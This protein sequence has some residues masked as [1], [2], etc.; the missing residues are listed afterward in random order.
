MRNFINKFIFYNIPSL[1]VYINNQRASFILAIKKLIKKDIQ[2]QLY[3][4]YITKNIKAIL[5]NSGGYNKE[6][7][8]PLKELI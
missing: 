6:K 7:W 1:K 2:I 8:K 5:V 4:Q 3:K